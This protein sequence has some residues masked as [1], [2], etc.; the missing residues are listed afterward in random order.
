MTIPNSV[1]IKESWVRNI[2][3]N[4]ICQA[5]TP[6]QTEGRSFIL[7]V[8][9]F[10]NRQQAREQSDMAERGITRR[11]HNWSLS[12]ANGVDPPT[13]DEAGSK[14]DPPRAWGSCI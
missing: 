14:I 11:K 4:L 2:L 10:T 9:I 3:E 5:A 13:R 8:D 6:A 7:S 12:Q 1:T